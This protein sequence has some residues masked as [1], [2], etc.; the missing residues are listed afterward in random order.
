MPDITQ[1]EIDKNIHFN[2]ISLYLAW[3]KNSIDN[4]PDELITSIYSQNAVPLISW[5][6]WGTEISTRNDGNLKKG[7]KILQHIAQGDFD[8][9]IRNFV[10]LLKNYDRP[11]FLRFAHEFDN[12]QYPWSLK[13]DN[14]PG[15][16]KAAWRHVYQL[17]DPDGANKIVMVQ[18]PWKA[19]DMQTYYPGD[20]FVDW[21]GITALNYDFL[22][23]DKKY[24]S[25]REIYQALHEELKHFQ[26]KPVML[27]EFG[28]LNLLNRRKEW[29]EKALQ[30]INS[31]YTEVSGIVL[32]NSAYDKNIPPNNLYGEGDL[33]WTTRNFNEI[34]KKIKP[35][36]IYTTENPIPK[37]NS[38][39]HSKLLPVTRYGI[40][41]VK[42][43]KGD[44]WMHSYQA[45]T[46]KE[47]LKD[48]SVM[49]SAGFNTIQFTEKGIY[50]YNLLKY[51]SDY[52]LNV[53]YKFK[54]K[55]PILFSE[56]KPQFEKPNQ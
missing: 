11:V 8:D 29:I 41:G 39:P 14:T 40:R 7:Q 16:F 52:Q 28:S 36:V 2:L 6:P 50:D 33:D 43:N 22:N 9:Y 12:P 13:G 55:E 48:F 3:N 5:E 51:S 53:I 31:E 56:K 17:I 45:L 26:T 10:C 30:T 32:F 21:I 19:E 47:L 24:H 27:S 42:Y 18:N 44:D 23:E 1:L 46:E 20:E 15:D 35:S 34:E 49:K 38:T 4:F 37:N 54:L 25:F